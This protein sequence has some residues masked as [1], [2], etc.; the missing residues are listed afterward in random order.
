MFISL[1]SKE[2]SKGGHAKYVDYFYNLRKEEMTSNFVILLLIQSKGIKK[3]EP[4]FL[5]FPAPMEPKMIIL[6]FIQIYMKSL[7]S[8][9]GFF[10]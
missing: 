6:D 2:G 4:L 1:F 5:T 3:V 9:D 7:F 8:M 10:F